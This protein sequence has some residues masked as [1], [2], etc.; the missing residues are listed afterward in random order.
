[1]EPVTMNSVEIAFYKAGEAAGIV[2]TMARMIGDLRAAGA[3]YKDDQTVAEKL[4][5]FANQIEGEAAKQQQVY[6]QLVEQAIG[7]RKNQRSFSERLRQTVDGALKG[8]R[9]C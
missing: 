5:S 9:G 4:E 3:H 7:I 2:G 1:M 6:L 8:W